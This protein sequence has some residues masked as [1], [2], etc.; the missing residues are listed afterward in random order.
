MYHHTAEENFPQSFRAFE[1]ALKIAEEVKGTITSVFASFWFGI[2]LAYNCEF[3]KAVPYMQ[4]AIEMNVAAKNLWGIATIKAHSAYFCYFLPGKINLGFETSAQSLRLVEETGD[5]FPKGFAYTA[6]GFSLFGRGFFEEAEKYL[7]KG[8]ECLE[9]LNE[10]LWNAAGYFYL[11]EINFVLGKFQKSEAFY[12]RAYRIYEHTR[13]LPSW[14]GCSKVGL[15]RAKVMNNEKDVD[16][17]SLYTVS[18]NNKIKA[19]DGRNL[20]Y[21]GE[22]L[23]NVQDKYIEEAERWIQKAIEAD[24]RNGMR[25]NLGRDYSLYAELFKRKGDRLKAGEILGRTIEILKECGADEW[26]KKY[27]KE[28]ASIS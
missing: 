21:I 16:L 17:E 3:E 26:V 25:F 12:E 28:L 6:H 5:I 11:G 27:E 10:N 4:R 20:R 24:Q 22:I 14:S 2:A 23:L 19:V 13:L 8:I 18:R 9:R 1:E 7:L 15:A